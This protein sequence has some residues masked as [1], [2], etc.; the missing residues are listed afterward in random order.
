M[1]RRIAKIVRLV[2]MAAALVALIVFMILHVRA[3]LGTQ[4]SK[5]Y[6][7]LYIMLTLWAAARVFTL[8]K[9]LFQK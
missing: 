8:S 1:V 3:G 4:V 2:I 6:L 9:D 7:G 5:L